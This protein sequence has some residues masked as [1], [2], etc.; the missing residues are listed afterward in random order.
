MID[1]VRLQFSFIQVIMLL[2]IDQ[3]IYQLEQI[4]IELRGGS[5]VNDL[6]P[7]DLT[8]NLS[9]DSPD[10]ELINLIVFMVV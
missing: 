8:S 6:P 2:I 10:N 9:L 4:N 5:I 7:Y 3:D 1:L